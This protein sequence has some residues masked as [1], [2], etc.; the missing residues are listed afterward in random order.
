MIFQFASWPIFPLL[1]YRYKDICN[2]FYKKLQYE[3]EWSETPK[4]RYQSTGNSEAHPGKPMGASSDPWG[5]SY[6]EKT[7]FRQK[8]NFRISPK[9]WCQSI[10]LEKLTE[11]SVNFSGPRPRGT[12]EK[13]VFQFT[14]ITWIYVNSRKFKV[15]VFQKFLM[16]I[17]AYWR[18]EKEYMWFLGPGSMGT[19]EKSDFRKNFNF[20]YMMYFQNFFMPIEASWRAE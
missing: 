19:S 17:D 15:E 3:R 18:G 11:R 4:T 9:F 6:T 8:I 7:V 20:L 5:P 12:P 2:F 10:E 13:S 14:W 1:L 16:P